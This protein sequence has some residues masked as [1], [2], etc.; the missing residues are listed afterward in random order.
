MNRLGIACATLCLTGATFGLSASTAAPE[1]RW[2]WAD[3]PFDGTWIIQPNLTAFDL[4]SPILSLDAGVFRRTD[5]RT[6]LLE[7]PA[8][9]A[10]HE[11]K[12]QVSFDSASV[13]VKDRRHIEMVESLAAKQ[14]W[15]SL[16]TLSDDGRTLTLDFEDDRAAKPV[17]GSVAYEHDGEPVAGA[18]PISG[19][20]L[21][22]KLTQLSVS[23]LTLTIR[24]D[25]VEMTRVSDSPD[26]IT[27]F[28][29][30]QSDGR[31]ADGKTDAH[32]Y[33]LN[34]YLPR[35]SVAVS[36]LEPNML[37]INRSQGGQLVEISRALV[38]DD[39]QTMIL[40]QI[41]W[42]CQAKTI[43]TLKLKK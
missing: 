24:T 22:K 14:V 12:G 26:L 6:G 19:T 34:G 20:W 10:S 7:V 30:A 13:R 17:T 25:A 18:Q 38:S 33:P 15:K 11:V 39:G 3:H 41:D 36:R 8:D 21:P 35:A 29:L 2:T 4:R 27:N 16:Y 28:S 37:Q 32:E 31:S 1:G 42:L 5:C 43:F 40:S 9:G 23:G